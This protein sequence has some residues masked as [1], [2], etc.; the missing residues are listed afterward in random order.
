VIKKE[1]NIRILTYV[2]YDRILF[3]NEVNKFNLK[4][5]F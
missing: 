2:T 1:T 4:I 5:V 3:S